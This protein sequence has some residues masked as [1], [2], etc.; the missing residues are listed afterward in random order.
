MSFLTQDFL[1]HTIY[2][3]LCSYFDHNSISLICNV[4]QIMI[5]YSRHKGFS[6]YQLNALEAYA[7]SKLYRFIACL[8][9]SEEAAIVY[10]LSWNEDTQNDQIFI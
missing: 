7:I 8:S 2:K 6:H 1:K 5:E 3:I 10:L 9:E 4:F